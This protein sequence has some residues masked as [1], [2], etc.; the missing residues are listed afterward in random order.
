MR[1]AQETDARYTRDTG[2]NTQGTKRTQETKGNVSG[3]SVPD[4]QV[5]TC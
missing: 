2:D 1:D 5:D 4:K 3:E